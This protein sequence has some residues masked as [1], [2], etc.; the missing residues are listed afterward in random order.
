M[1]ESIDEDVAGQMELTGDL[2]KS[3]LEIL[4]GEVALCEE[5][6]E[7]HLEREAGE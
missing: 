5:T 2:V 6:E 7:C 1:L 3:Y 4:W